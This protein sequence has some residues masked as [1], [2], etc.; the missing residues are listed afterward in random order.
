MARVLLTEDDLSVRTFVR[1][2]L[3][4]DGH[5]VVEAED[6]AEALALLATQDFHCDLIVSDI[7]MPEVDGITLA[8]L[9]KTQRPELLIILMTGFFNER[10]RADHLDGVVLEI[11]SKPFGLTDIRRA[12][13]P[14]VARLAEPMSAAAAVAC[15]GRQSAASA[16]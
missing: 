5:D 4:L 9:A 11:L 6:G 7:T 16:A 15:G 12:V 3:Q 14:A 2:A 1:R 8:C 10:E 13:S